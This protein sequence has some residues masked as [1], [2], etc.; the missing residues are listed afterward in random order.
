MAKNKKTFDV[1]PWQARVPNLNQMTKST[2]VKAAMQEEIDDLYKLLNRYENA[3]DAA[4]DER[5]R[6][7]KKL[8]EVREKSAFWYNKYKNLARTRPEAK[9]KVSEQL[10]EKRIKKV[11]QAVNPQFQ[12]VWRHQ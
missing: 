8:E 5:N 6:A 3:L 2:I 7:L 10:D 12:S 9:R 11:L 1:K 4:L